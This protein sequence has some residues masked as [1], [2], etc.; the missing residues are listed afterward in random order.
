MKSILDLTAREVIHVP[1]REIS[2]KVR[3]KLAKL[4]LMWCS[5]V[6]YLNKT[7]WEDYQESTC[8]R[9]KEGSFD[10]IHFYKKMGYTV[11][12]ID[13]LT[14]FNTEKNNQMETKT[15][16]A[17]L[18]SI[19]GQNGCS[20]F[21]KAIK[22]ILIEQVVT[23]ENTEFVVDEKYL[24]RL[25]ECNKDQLQLLK[26]IGIEK[27]EGWSRDATPRSSDYY[28]LTRNIGEKL[29]FK[30]GK[31]NSYD[32]RAVTVY[33]TAEIA[34]QEAKIFNLMMLMRN[35]ARYHNQIDNFKADWTKSNQ[36][37]S[38]IYL[39][40]TTETKLRVSTRYGDNELLFA[41]SVSSEQRAQEML[42]EFR[43]EI[44]EVAP[45]L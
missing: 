45:F 39:Y 15:T 9:V 30:V 32:A 31:G 38:G 43:Q 44:M 27:K 41:I 29:P 12:T 35:W 36:G 23:P 10:S 24:K 33:R 40:T 26:S 5:G 2:D 18:L 25:S 1:T 8:Y 22:E 4:G 34:E 16:K 13:Q 37:K 42:D 17:K 19:W 11:L 28:F 6:S 20:D 21:N 14:E 3:V 7:N